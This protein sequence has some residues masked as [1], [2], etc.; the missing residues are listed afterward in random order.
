M[1]PEPSLPMPTI[2]ADPGYSAEE[3][4]QMIAEKEAE[5]RDKELEIKKTELELKRP[6]RSWKTRVLSRA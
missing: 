3:I 1:E 6:R 4:R 2:P 5:I